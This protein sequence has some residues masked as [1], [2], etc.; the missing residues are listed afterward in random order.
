MF[1]FRWGKKD[2]PEKELLENYKL[3]GDK[4]EHIIKWGHKKNQAEKNANKEKRTPIKFKAPEGGK[5]KKKKGS[6]FSFSRFN[7]FGKSKRKRTPRAAQRSPKEEPPQRK[8]VK[9]LIKKFEA[10][11][12]EAK[13]AEKET[14][15]G[16]AKEAAKETARGTSNVGKAKVPTQTS[17]IKADPQRSGVHTA[18]I[19]NEGQF[20]VLTEEEK[21]SIEVAS[22]IEGSSNGDSSETD[23]DGKDDS[24]EKDVPAKEKSAYLVKKQKSGINLSQNKELLMQ[25]SNLLE[26]S[27][28]IDKK[29][30]YPPKKKNDENDLVITPKASTD[31]DPGKEVQTKKSILKNIIKMPLSFASKS[32]K[33]DISETKKESVKLGGGENQRR[34]GENAGTKKGAL[35]SKGTTDSIH[36]Q[37]SD[38]DK[39]DVSPCEE[40]DAKSEDSNY[41]GKMNFNNFIPNFKLNSKKNA[42]LRSNKKNATPMISSKLKMNKKNSNIG[43]SFEQADDPENAKMEESTLTRQDIQEKKKNLVGRAKLMEKNLHRRKEAPQEDGANNIHRKMTKDIFEGEGIFFNLFPPLLLTENSFDIC[44]ISPIEDIIEVIYSICNNNK[45]EAIAK[46][47]MCKENNEKCSNVLKITLDKLNGTEDSVLSNLTKNM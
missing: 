39:G 26:G 32:F 13:G 14:A 9:G 11:K 40:I 29:K 21:K 22:L 4:K 44:P 47:K 46:L 20:E 27:C 23:R 10:A 25:K 19:V 6:F 28:Q 35:K 42:T 33:K 30:S 18:P 3:Q 34:E 41:S 2:K 1:P 8:E 31:A 17:A 37:K 38:H 45:E 16:A 12:G 15:K 24:V 5:N 7:F 36:L 43:S